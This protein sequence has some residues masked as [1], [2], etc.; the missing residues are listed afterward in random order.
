MNIERLSRQKVKEWILHL[1]FKIGLMS[2][3]EEE[4]ETKYQRVKSPLTYCR[5]KKTFSW[6]LGRFCG[7][8]MNSWSSTHFFIINTSWGTYTLRGNFRITCWVHFWPI[9]ASN[10]IFSLKIRIL[11]VKKV[12]KLKKLKNQY[13]YLS[14]SV[15]TKTDKSQI[16]VPKKGT[17]SGWKLLVPHFRSKKNPDG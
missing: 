14:M 8:K 2:H 17:A 10:F 13:G 6:Y 16:V 15:R 5:L 11:L 12:G 1:L 9:L 4:T 7:W 3:P